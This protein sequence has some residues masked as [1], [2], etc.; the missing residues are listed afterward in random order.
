MY[1]RLA[2]AVAAHLEP[3]ILVV[4]EVLAVG[5][6]QF[7]KKC[8]GKMGEVARGGRTVLFVS[9]NMTAVKSFCT[10]GILLQQGSVAGDGT[11]DAVVHQFARL[12]SDDLT[13][14]LYHESGA[15]GTDQVKLLSARMLVDLPAT[16]QS[17]TVADPFR[18][19]FLYRV[20]DPDAQINLSLH[21]YNEEGACV[22]TSPSI[23]EP[24]WFDRDHPG[25]LCRS[26]CEIPGGL[27]N[28]GRF[29]ITLLFVQD[30]TNVIF[31][32]ERLL[33]FDVADD[34]R[35][36]GSWYGKWTGV[37]RPELRWQTAYLSTEPVCELSLDR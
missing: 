14:R 4:D 33:E 10:H 11:I 3:E 19:E 21:L 18:F 15:V 17:V 9:H 28:N 31:V 25:G 32:H 12:T 5:D 23:T 26:T 22:L 30:T 20:A 35:N 27:L 13:A 7:Q 2:F 1:V 8:L 6:A 37:V 24:G 16:V 29:S 36:R 34:N